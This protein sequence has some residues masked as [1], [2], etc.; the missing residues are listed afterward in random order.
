MVVLLV[1]FLFLLSLPG[2]FAGWIAYRLSE[3]S[4]ASKA[5][6]L[7][8]ALPPIIFVCILVA[9]GLIIATAEMGADGGG[10]SRL[11]AL[12]SGAA[13]S[14]ILVIGIVGLPVN[15][16]VSWLLVSWLSGKWS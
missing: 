13:L 3:D 16:L 8:L 6:N 7:G 9:I 14:T 4:S 15:M 5:K 1:V 11:G 12:G 10:D 2:Q